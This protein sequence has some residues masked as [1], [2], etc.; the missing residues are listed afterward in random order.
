M[1]GVTPGLFPGET[2]YSLILCTYLVYEVNCILQIACLHSKP[3]QL[4]KTQ[5]IGLP[6]NIQWVQYNEPAFWVL[7]GSLVPE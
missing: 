2:W 3:I 4:P 6:Q 1:H 5:A 7:L